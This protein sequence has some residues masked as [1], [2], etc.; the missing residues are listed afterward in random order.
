MTDR[1]GRLCILV[2]QYQI[3]YT[4][5]LRRFAMSLVSAT[6]ARKQLFRL[7]DSVTE[8]G[9]P[10]L[11]TGRRHN[12]VLVGED[13]WKAIQE[14]LYLSQIPGMVASIRAGMATPPEDMAQE[15]NW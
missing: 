5:G 9:E 6:E 11:I 2:Q 3:P 13:D 10:I 15:L 4:V 8:N 7:V 14:T 12:A 1:Q